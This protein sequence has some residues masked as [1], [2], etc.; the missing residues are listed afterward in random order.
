MNILFKSIISQ[1]VTRKAVSLK[2]IKQKVAEAGSASIKLDIW[3]DQIPLEE[4]DRAYSFVG[5]E[6]ESGT[7]I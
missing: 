3:E 1:K 4:V 6:L 2:D 7:T 5:S